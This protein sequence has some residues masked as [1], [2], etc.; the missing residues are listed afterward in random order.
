MKTFLCVVAALILVA[1]PAEAQA[2]DSV[3]Q[4]PTGSSGGVSG[5]GEV[6]SEITFSAPVTLGCEALT[7]AATVNIDFSTK[8]C[9]TLTLAGDVTFTTSNIVAGRHVSV[10]VTGDASERTVVFPTWRFN[11]GPAATLGPA[12]LTEIDLD[13]RGTTN[14][15]TIAHITQAQSV[16]VDSNNSVLSVESGVKLTT[17]TTNTYAGN[18]AGHENATGSENT[19]IGQ[20]ACYQNTFS[21]N[22]A[23]GYHVMLN[24][25]D[26]NGSN[27]A[28]GDS[29]MEN[30]SGLAT[31]TRNNAFGYQ[32][33]RGVMSGANDNNSFGYF[34]LKAVTSG[35]N[36]A[37]FGNS[38]LAGVTSGTSNIGIGDHA[39]RS[40]TTTSNNI[41][42][43]DI[44]CDTCTGSRTISIGIA[45]LLQG[46]STDDTTCVG[47]QCGWGTDGSN[48]LTSG[49]SNSLYGAYATVSAATAANRGAFGANAI[50]TEDNSV[51]LGD[52]NVTYLNV[53]NAHRLHYVAPTSYNSGSCTNESGTGTEAWGTI[54]ATC[55]N[56]TAIVLFSDS[57]TYAAAPTCIVVPM[58]GAATAAM[59]SF[60]YTTATT[61]ITITQ[62]GNVGAETWSFQCSE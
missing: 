54:T 11:T 46:T 7:Y 44:S 61:G 5:G 49:D 30:P 17:G 50:A 35:D 22:T 59:A 8:P 45:S 28:Y 13:A 34:A 6:T 31:G 48:K 37:A 20:G 26:A 18:R 1:L 51:K 9:K 40:I 55:N 38:A 29:A 36:N 24:L 15:T 14:A 53:G 23:T 32:S 56:Q 39:G 2:T 16:A 47:F 42:E 60:S 43:G 4:P 33:M 52:T 58:N 10:Y 62:T 21:L 25:N 19:C 57:S 27:T 3:L 41:A 12:T